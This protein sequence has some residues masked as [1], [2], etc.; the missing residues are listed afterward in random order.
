MVS[1]PHTTASQIAPSWNRL[2]SDFSPQNFRNSAACGESGQSMAWGSKPRMRMQ[3]M[4]IATA[5]SYH[6]MSGVGVSGQ[7][8]LDRHSKATPLSGCQP[9]QQG[10]GDGTPRI[11]GGG[12]PPGHG[13]TSWQG[14]HGKLRL[15]PGAPQ[16]LKRTDQSRA[17]GGLVGRKSLLGSDHSPQTYSS[18][19]PAPPYAQDV[20]K[21]DAAET[22]PPPARGTAQRPEDF[23]CYYV[24]VRS[25]PD[26]RSGVEEETR[27]KVSVQLH[28]SSSGLI[29]LSALSPLCIPPQASPPPAQTHTVYCSP[30]LSSASPYRHP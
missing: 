7:F 25:D 11:H 27:C 22:A 3:P 13:D 14:A 15:C 23:P 6:L 29:P 24:R 20:A 17:H 16:P 19:A 30:H 4:A 5:S 1:A 2:S 12:A 28:R 9:C 21:A 18:D 26:P 8:P 10:P